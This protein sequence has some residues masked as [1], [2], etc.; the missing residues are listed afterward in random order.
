MKS[1]IHKLGLYIVDAN[2]N[3]GDIEELI[4]LIEN[5]TDC[6]C[7]VINS[8]SKEFEWDDDLEINRTNVDLG[9]YEEYFT[10]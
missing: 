3:Y 8:K 5:H 2:G 7:E 6:H 1:N 10:K 9:C 4:A